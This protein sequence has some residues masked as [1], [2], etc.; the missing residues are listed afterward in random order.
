VDGIRSGN[1]VLF[2]GIGQHLVVTL[3]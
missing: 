2:L 3:F 1:R